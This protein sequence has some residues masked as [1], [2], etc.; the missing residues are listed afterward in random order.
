MLLALHHIVINTH[1]TARV[2]RIPWEVALCNSRNMG[3]KLLREP[4]GGKEV[5]GVQRC[6]MTLE[7]KW[8]MLAGTR[9]V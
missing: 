4:E 9:R 2:S 1:P 7:E 3:K 5:L 6:S 8:E